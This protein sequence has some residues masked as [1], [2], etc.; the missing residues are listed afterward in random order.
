MRKI[1]RSLSD[2]CW[3]SIS[4]HPRNEFAE[5]FPN[6]SYPSLSQKPGAV[7][8]TSTTSSCYPWVSYH[9]SPSPPLTAL[10]SIL[11]PIFQSFY[12]VISEHSVHSHSCW[13][14][15]ARD[16]LMRGNNP[17][18]CCTDRAGSKNCSFFSFWLSKGPSH[19]LLAHVPMSSYFMNVIQAT[20]V[21]LFSLYMPK[22]GQKVYFCYP[23]SDTMSSEEVRI[24]FHYHFSFLVLRMKKNF[25]YIN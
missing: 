5:F 6:N 15:H 22:P 20:P 9:Y 3:A 23:G 4:Q 19:S 14:T 8:S 7:S 18:R 16:K 2:R 17:Q 24:S 1:S 11:V 12:Q 13:H 21:C 25:L 10:P